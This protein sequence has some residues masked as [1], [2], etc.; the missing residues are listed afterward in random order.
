MCGMCPPFA[1]E[2]SKWAVRRQDG[3][4][5]VSPPYPLDQTRAFATWRQAFDFADTMSRGLA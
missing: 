1:H 5:V 4:W 2:P 3:R